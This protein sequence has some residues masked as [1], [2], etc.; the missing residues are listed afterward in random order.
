[1]TTWLVQ[2]YETGPGQSFPNLHEITLT[3]PTGGGWSVVSITF[4]GGARTFSVLWG[5]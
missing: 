2:Y 5:K 1:M 3:Q 4:H